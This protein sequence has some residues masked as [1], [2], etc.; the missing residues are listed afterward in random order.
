MVTN[1]HGG[2]F[3][4]DSKVKTILQET[5]AIIHSTV[6]L[7]EKTLIMKMQP[8]FSLSCYLERHIF[9]P[10]LLLSSSIVVSSVRQ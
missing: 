9:S 7:R 6:T 2:R 4:P 5:A 8:Y 10:L 1:G 3:R